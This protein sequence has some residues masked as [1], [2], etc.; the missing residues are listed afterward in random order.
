MISLRNI[1]WVIV[2][3]TSIDTWCIYKVLLGEALFHFRCSFLNTRYP[4]SKDPRPLSKSMTN[5]SITSA[6]I[7]ISP[8]VDVLCK[9]NLPETTL[10]KF[11]TYPCFQCLSSSCHVSENWI[12]NIWV[13]VYSRCA[14]WFFSIHLYIHT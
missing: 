12:F 14:L 5:K 2:G 8:K 6:M 9:N 10:S 4:L 11:S 1:N 3:M 13:T 7:I